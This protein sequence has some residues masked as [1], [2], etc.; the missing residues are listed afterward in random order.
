M[1]TAVISFL[2]SGKMLKE[3]NNTIITLI[4][5][6]LCPESVRDFRP[7]SCCNVLYKAATKLICARLRKVLPDLISENQSGFVQGRY[8]GYNILICQDLVRFYGR[9]SCKP[10]CMI[11]VDL[12]K[13]YDTIEWP[14]IEEMLTALQFPKVFIDLVMLC[15]TTPKFSLLIN[16]EMNGFF[17]SKRGLRQG[18]PISPLLF[19]LG[20]EYLSRILKEVGHKEA[21][22]FHDRCKG[23]Q[24]NH[25][26]FADDLLLFCH[27]DYVSILLMLQGLKLFSSTSG[28]FPNEEKTEVYCSGMAEEETRR[29]LAVSGYKRSNLPFRYLGIPI[30]MRRIT[31]GE[32]KGVIEK[33]VKRIRVWS[34]RHLSYMAR[35]QLVN[36]VLLAIH[37]Y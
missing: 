36:S 3:V 10:S 15:I 8:I 11:K 18:D 12:R 22:K 21:F 29:V 24:L 13:A 25:L 37:S 1:T 16:G 14:F 23:L 28:L 5:K 27:G 20:M 34:T 4:P 30:C 9:K 31:A 7:I 6:V 33:M 32:C 35:I 26:C 17:E 19:V 2:N